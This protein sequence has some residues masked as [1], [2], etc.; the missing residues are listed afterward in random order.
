MKELILAKIYNNFHL[1]EN[2]KKLVD[3]C[4]VDE[5][6]L[7]RLDAVLDVMI[8]YHM[9]AD[10]LVPYILFQAQ[11]TDSN[12]SD[13]LASKYFTEEQKKLYDTFITVKDVRALTRSGEVE[14]IRKMFVAICQDMRI[15]IVKFATILF[16]LNQI[17]L[18]LTQEDKDYVQMVND[19]FAPLAERLGLMQFKFDFEDKCFELL[20]PKVFNELKNNHLLEDEAN[21]KQIQT[22]KS[23]LQNILD[24]LNVKGEIQ[25]RQKHF[26]SIYK[27]L[28][29]KKSSLENIY[30]IIAMRVLVPTVEDC[31]SVLGKI[32]AIYKPMQGR[33][34]DYIA[35]PKPNGYQSLHTTIIAE[36][37][38]PLEVQIR[39]FDMHKYSEYGIAAHWIYKEKRTQNNFDQKLTWFRQMLD[40]ANSLSSEEFV[41]TLKI[42]L[43]GESIFV[44]TP[45]GKVLEFPLGATVLDFAYAVH[46]G[47][48]NTCV[49]A[50][51]NGKMVPIVTELQNG[52]V[53]EILTNPNS[54]GPSRDWLSYV[55]TNNA[56][57]KIRAFFK[58]ELKEENIRIGKAM[59]EQ[60]I[61]AKNLNLSK[62]TKEEYLL[63]IANSNMMDDLDVLYAEIGAGSLSI[64][65]VIGRLVNFYNKD[66]ISQFREE[67][68][69]VKKNKDG[70][71]VDGD[72]G[73]LIRYA[74]CC[75][76]VTGDDIV[77]Y[78]SRGRGVTIHR[79]NCP[80]LK[81]LEP[82]R[83]IKAEWQDTKGASFTAVIKI[84]TDLVGSVINTLNNIA[85]SFKNKLKGFGF[86]EIKDEYVFNIILL[87][88]NKDEI[89]EAIKSFQNLK[90][91][92]KV[93][94]SE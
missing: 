49:G 29:Q 88:S 22:T 74:G 16:D 70:V 53:V 63:K 72:S 59:L 57:S 45:K 27:K 24:E 85:I 9:Q 10:I 5:I 68:I 21:Q 61:K 92:R 82:E 20:E 47:V 86:K 46:S 83:L 14:S 1:T 38:R 75:S 17:K 69:T 42:D 40:N 41:E 30:D 64:N 37:N 55:K 79:S 62:T 76:P 94:R 15:V 23:K 60:A 84:H 80:N 81:Y 52:D 35:S 65:S 28:K 34:K 2:E 7:P 33:V 4:F 66:N 25:S 12:E 91:V 90:F 19:I 39:T 3:D 36:N 6:N 54:K 73:M 13:K 44:Q 78:I 48:G 56:R 87:V 18:P 31:Y 67:T 50:K 32:H 89:D 11:K 71:L 26:S 51:I 43:Y 8:E 58:S 93:Y 77:G